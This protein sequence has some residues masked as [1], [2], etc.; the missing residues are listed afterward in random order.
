MRSPRPDRSSHI[1]L[2]SSFSSLLFNFFFFFLLLFLSILI[3]LLGAILHLLILP[4]LHFELFCI[5]DM[6]IKDIYISVILRGFSRELSLF[7]SIWGATIR[8]IFFC[9][10]LFY[11]SLHISS[12]SFLLYYILPLLIFPLLIFKL[13]VVLQTCIL[14]AHWVK[15]H[16][17]C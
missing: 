10:I 16:S 17:T 14:N 13:F 7:W 8:P 1:A 9:F 4:L 2:F 3:L 15:V 11:S 12:Y 5:T 6:H